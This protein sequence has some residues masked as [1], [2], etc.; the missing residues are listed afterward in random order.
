MRAGLVALA[1]L[2][3]SP[4]AAAG[5]ASATAQGVAEATVIQPI[6]VSVITNLD[7]GMLT[8]SHTMGGTV[9]VDPANGARYGGGASPACL[10]GGACPFVHASR[11]AVRGEAGRDYSVRAPAGIMASGT[12]LDGSS[13]TAPDLAI[14]SIQ[15][16]TQSRPD[17]GFSGTLDGNGRDIFDVG[18][19]LMVPAGTPAARYRAVLPV[20]V[21]YG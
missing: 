8:A 9:T 12:L 18:G 10:G 14:A 11:F 7:F 1:L 21:T 6:V 4:A 13:G 3:A 20:I 16:R 19:A 5:G 17:G 2:A 15:V